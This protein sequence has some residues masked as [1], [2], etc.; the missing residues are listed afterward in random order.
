MSAIEL[1]METGFALAGIVAV[2]LNLLIPQELESFNDDSVDGIQEGESI[3]I[4]NDDDDDL[5]YDEV[6]KNL[7]VVHDKSLGSTRDTSLLPT[8]TNP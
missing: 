3:E 6:N 4:K 5:K 1:V 7:N 2:I 8:N